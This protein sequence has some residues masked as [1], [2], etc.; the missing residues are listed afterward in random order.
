MFKPGQLVVLLDSS[1]CPTCGRLEPDL[2]IG[3]VY[4]V[5][6]DPGEGYVVLKGVEMLPEHRG[7]RYRRLALLS[8]ADGVDLVV[9]SA[10]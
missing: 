9:V 1:L 5:E 3:R 8:F 6:E 10:Q 4:K 7:V 2:V